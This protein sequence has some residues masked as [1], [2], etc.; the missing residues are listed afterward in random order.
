MDRLPDGKTWVLLE[1][2]I[3]ETK[4]HRKS[5]TNQILHKFNDDWVFYTFLFYCNQN[6]NPN[7]EI[8]R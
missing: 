2:L 6:I 3:A 5:I 4:K 1:S 7:Q 8:W